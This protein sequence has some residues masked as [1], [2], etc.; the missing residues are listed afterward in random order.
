MKPIKTKDKTVLRALGLGGYF[1][2]GFIR[3]PFSHE[4]ARLE[5]I[6]IGMQGLGGPGVHQHQL[7]LSIKKGKEPG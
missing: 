6:L 4:P 1:G 5:C 7:T 2:G 3:G